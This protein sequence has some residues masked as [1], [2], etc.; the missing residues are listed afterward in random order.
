MQMRIFTLR[1]NPVTEG[2]DESA[3]AEFV[4]DKEVLS[5]DNHFFVK[6]E[7]PYIAIVVRYR[8]V[9]PAVPA[10]NTS[11][12]EKRRDESWRKLLTEADWPLFNTLRTWRSELAKEQGIPPY[13]ICNNRQLAELVKSRPRTLAALGQI[14]GFGEAKLKKYGKDLLALLAEEAPQKRETKHAKE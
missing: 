4:K 8:A 14:E 11:K 7:V 3:V 6:D 10:D 2:F 12:S 1:F 9:V 5:M 13:V